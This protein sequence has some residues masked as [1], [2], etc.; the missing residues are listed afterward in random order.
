[1][2]SCDFAEGTCLRIPKDHNA[3]S[4]FLML[5]PLPPPVHG[6]SMVYRQF[7]DNHQ[8]DDNFDFDVINLSTS[9]QMTEIGKKSWIKYWRFLCIYGK[10]LYHL[11]LKRY[12]ACYLAIS[13]R[14]IGFL[15]DF[16][17]IMLC[18]MFRYPVFLHQ[19]N[20]GMQECVTQWPY[21]WLLPIAYRNTT[22]I[23]LSQLLYEDIA[24]V[25]AREQVRI[26][27]NGIPDVMA[28]VPCRI[29][30]KKK[31]HLLF[32]AN[33]N[34]SKGIW[35]LLDA[36]TQLSQYDNW[37][38]DIIGKDTAEISQTRLKQEIEKRRL[39][40]RVLYH[41]ACYGEEKL[42]HYRNADC[43]IFPTLDDCFPLT[44]L[45]AMQFELPC[46]ASAVGGIPDII[47]TGD[48]GNGILCKPDNPMEL[49]LA[50]EQLIL[51][52]EL[53][54]KMGK[55]GRMRYLDKFQQAHFEQRLKDILTRLK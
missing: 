9:R 27:A 35:I 43:F 42:S 23:L 20:K 16:P 8:S 30:Q 18:K 10:L 51:D 49:K 13:C 11:C 41:G 40:K 36:L 28:P 29:E 22:V 24:S 25:V 39:T 46:V 52:E 19:H 47:K 53:R 38:C 55:A 14:K 15:K 34:S 48:G 44:L 6:A 31:V 2:Q 37:V 50:I 33:L 45:E 54:K 26:C 17:L 1:M 3:M 4:K 21:R 12:S 5:V 7:L 32:L